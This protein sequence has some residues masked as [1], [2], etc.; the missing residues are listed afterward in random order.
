MQRLPAT[1]P[2]YV[3]RLRLP[4][5]SPGYQETH[6]QP[7]RQPRRINAN[8]NHKYGGDVAVLRLYKMPDTLQNIKN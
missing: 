2:G 6:R 5:T 7:L 8:Y 1:S 4:A 3:S